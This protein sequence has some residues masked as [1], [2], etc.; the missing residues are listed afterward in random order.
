[1]VVASL[2]YWNQEGNAWMQAK[3]KNTP[4][5]R[6]R[7][8]ALMVVVGAVLFRGMLSASTLIGQANIAMVPQMTAVLP[9][10]PPQTHQIT[11]G[12]YADDIISNMSLSDEIAQMLVVSISSPAL[13][14]DQLEMIQQQH[15]GGA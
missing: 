14:V 8:I 13:P 15:V 12:E 11:P 3:D 4:V 9:T 10:L 5:P 1:M 7:W 6:W 2:G